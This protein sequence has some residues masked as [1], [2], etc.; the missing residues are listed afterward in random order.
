[1]DEI[2][3][4]NG[5]YSA[6]GITYG[7]ASL[8]PTVA[9]TCVTL[10]GTTGKVLCKSGFILGGSNAFTIIGWGKTS[11]GGEVSLYCERP[12][13]G[14]ALLRL[15]VEGTTHRLRFSYSDMSG[16]TQHI[17]APG[18][19]PVGNDNA[20]HM[21]AAVRVGNTA[22]I[23]QDEQVVGYGAVPAANDYT[24]STG[25]SANIGW[26]PVDNFFWNGQVD[27]IAVFNFA[28]TG[29]NIARC[30]RVGMGLPLDVLARVQQRMGGV[31]S[32]Q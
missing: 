27:E 28:L 14:A 15:Q 7:V 31:P 25:P 2:A 30:Y 10:N 9:E 6:T 8:L 16:G 20:V 24:G 17:L 29:D 26:E 1:M 3:A 19:A 32:Y 4:N 23:Y 12:T 13:A 21:F 5:T 22:Q 11:S 18:G